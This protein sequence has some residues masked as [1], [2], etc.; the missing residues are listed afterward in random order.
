MRDMTELAA[1]ENVLSALLTQME[2]E[3]GWMKET[4]LEALHALQQEMRM[5]WPDL[6]SRK[7]KRLRLDLF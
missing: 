6:Q 1:K 2:V 4:S 5:A 3:L 7:S